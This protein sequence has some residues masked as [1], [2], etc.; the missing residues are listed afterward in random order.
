MDFLGFWITHGRQEGCSAV[1]SSTL[2]SHLHPPPMQAI[3][4]PKSGV[5]KGGEEEGKRAGQDRQGRSGWAYCTVKGH[6]VAGRQ[7]IERRA[8]EEW[9]EGWNGAEIER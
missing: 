7:T 3:H 4:Y 9:E 2:A 1:G 8:R 6:K 5:V